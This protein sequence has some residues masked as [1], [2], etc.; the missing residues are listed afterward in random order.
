MIGGAHPE[1]IVVEVR[2][3]LQEKEAQ[4]G[5]AAGP[6]ASRVEQSGRVDENTRL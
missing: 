6:D 4:R 2:A 5:L 1:V 3:Y